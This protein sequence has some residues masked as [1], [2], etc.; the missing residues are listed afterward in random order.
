MSMNVNTN[1]FQ[2]AYLLRLNVKK[3]PPSAEGENGQSKQNSGGANG[4]PPIMDQY[5]RESQRKKALSDRKNMQNDQ[6]SGNL[7]EMMLKLAERK[8]EV[9]GLRRDALSV[10]DPSKKKILENNLY[11]KSAATTDLDHDLNFSYN[12]SGGGFVGSEG[13]I[14]YVG[15]FVTTG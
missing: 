13:R 15:S 8:E 11:S 9:N 4:S 2:D 14:D 6:K 1:P 3:N 5:I 12:S 10:T 7:G